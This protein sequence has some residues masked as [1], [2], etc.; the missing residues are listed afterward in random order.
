MRRKRLLAPSIEIAMSIFISYRRA[1]SAEVTRTLYDNL[2]I[3]YGRENVFKDIDSIP[4]GVHF[5][6]HIAKALANCRVLTAVIGEGWLEARDHNNRRRLD[7][8]D[9]YVRL[10]IETALGLR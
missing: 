7:D 3:R 1:D 5:R 6:Q 4:P 8:V 2:V 9:D 10:E